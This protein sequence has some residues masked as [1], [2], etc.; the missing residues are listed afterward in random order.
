MRASE[1]RNPID[2]AA[3]KNQVTSS[4]DEERRSSKSMEDIE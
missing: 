1:S 3:A 2:L 4:R